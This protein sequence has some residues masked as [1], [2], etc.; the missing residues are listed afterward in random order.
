[1]KEL[2][3]KVSPVVSFILPLRLIDK[4]RLRNIELVIDSIRRLDLVKEIIIVEMDDSTKYKNDD[5]VKK[6][7][8]RDTGVFN[9][10]KARNI[11]ALHAQAN[12]LA[13]FDIDILVDEYSLFESISLL[14]DDI[15]AVSPWNTMYDV[16][17]D[18]YNNYTESKGAIIDNCVF[19]EVYLD[20]YFETKVK[21]RDVNRCLASGNVFV[22]KETFNK[23]G[24][25]PME[26]NGWGAED[27]IF[28]YLLF[29]TSGIDIL[30]YPCVHIPHKRQIVDTNNHKDYQ[31]NFHHMTDV[32]HM[33]DS[34]LYAYLLGSRSALVQLAHEIKPEDGHLYDSRFVKQTL[35]DNKNQWII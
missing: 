18:E 21:F 26:L 1:M 3:L 13:F 17:E 16:S 5:D 35:I 8:V 23:V 27:D 4:S 25:W 19:K 20:N 14:N 22:T 28:A 9:R 11:G 33:E 24:G 6:I 10:S 34:D 7:F 32:F 2:G 30:N 29:R 12:I 31:D 15:G